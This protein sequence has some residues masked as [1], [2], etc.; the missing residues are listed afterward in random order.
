MTNSKPQ[1]RK[2]KGKRRSHPRKMNTLRHQFDQIVQGSED[3]ALRTPLLVIAVFIQANKKI[4]LSRI[5]QVYPMD[6]SCSYKR[7]S[8]SS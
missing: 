2:K 1:A 5:R 8:F 6:N 4:A 3:S 7:H